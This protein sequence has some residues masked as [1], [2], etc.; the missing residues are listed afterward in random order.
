M[1][2][3]AQLSLIPAVL[4]IVSARLCRVWKK[5]KIR[6][7][8]IS[9][10][11][12]ACHKTG[13]VRI[14]ANTGNFADIEAL[15][16]HEKPLNSNLLL[17]YDAIKA[18]GGVLIMQT[19]TVKFQKEVPMCAALKID[20]PD[21]SIVFDQCQKIWMWKWTGDWEPAMLQNRIA[22][23]HVPYQIR[24]AY[25]KELCT[26]INDG[27]LIPYPHR[28]FGPPKGQNPLMAIV[29]PNKSK[30]RSVMDFWELN[31]YVNAFMADADVCASKLWEWQQHGS[32]VS[33]LDLRKAYLQVQ[34]HCGHFRQ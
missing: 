15:L 14:C 12:H 28:K 5:R 30:V 29:Q 3:C 26:C 33:L 9:S 24:L 7:T 4:T 2:H 22:E 18:L 23:Y 13:V 19:G 1:R 6:V 25:K 34:G 31:Q 27:W 21:F 17:G 32:N 11:T 10:E 8:T 16:V 20:Q